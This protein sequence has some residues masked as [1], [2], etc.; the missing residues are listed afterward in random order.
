MEGAVF[1]ASASLRAPSMMSVIFFTTDLGVMPCA[2]LYS[3]CLRRRRSVSS[4]AARIA[5]VTRSA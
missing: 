4:M 1:S 3:T 5:V 2:V